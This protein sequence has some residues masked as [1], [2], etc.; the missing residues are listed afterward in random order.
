MCLSPLCQPFKYQKKLHLNISTLVFKKNDLHTPQQP[1]G[2]SMKI[3]DR[4]NKSWIKILAIVWTTTMCLGSLLAANKLPSAG[5]R[6]LHLDKVIHFVMYFGFVVLWCLAA[7]HFTK[8]YLISIC[9]IGCILGVLMEV[10]QATTGLGRSFEWTDMIS[11]SLGVVL[12]YFLITRLTI[13]K[14]TLT[15]K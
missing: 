8:K 7:Q 5:I 10:G 12:G 13:S 2:A 3:M 15:K 9:I 4:M 14:I 1:N 11:N 6:I